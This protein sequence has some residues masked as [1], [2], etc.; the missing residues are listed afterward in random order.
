MIICIYDGWVYVKW[1]IKRDNKII[2]LSEN[3]I[4]SPIIVEPDN[5]FIIHGVVQD[6]MLQKPKKIVK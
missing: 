2:L 4:Y 1:Y 6:V 3:P 5:R